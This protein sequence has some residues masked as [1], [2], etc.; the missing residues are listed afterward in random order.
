VA[1]EL[2]NDRSVG[3]YRLRE[4]GLIVVV[5]HPLADMWVLEEIFRFRAYEPPAGARA[6]L[7]SLGR[8]LR[9]ADLGGH[10]GIF[11]LFVQ[12]SLPVAQLTSF[13][14]D[15]HNAALL[16]RCVAANRLEHRWRVVEAC[17]STH[18]GTVELE[19]SYHLSRAATAD[20]PLA[21]F[22]RAI[23]HAFPFLAGAAILE[24][25]RHEVSCLDAFPVLGDADLIKIDIEGGE[26][27]LLADP[28][29]SALSARAIVL[30]YHYSRASAP[31]DSDRIV[32]R[33]LSQAGYTVGVAS[34]GAD[35]AVIWGWKP[36]AGASPRSRA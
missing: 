10:A 14:P 22:Q 23:R 34:K 33:A 20:R 4:S 8:D 16:R 36:W 18:D 1:R 27:E 15:P 35:G 5:R 26:W 12:A 7:L 24:R 13:E 19:S 32:T 6:A 3:E 2:R 31:A 25:E 17:A 29:F 11:G 30:E 9:V 21:D 28:R